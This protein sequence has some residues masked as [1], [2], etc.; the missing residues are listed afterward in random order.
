MDAVMQTLES[1]AGEAEA[2]LAAVEAK[3]ASSE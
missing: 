3:L 1:R 2:R